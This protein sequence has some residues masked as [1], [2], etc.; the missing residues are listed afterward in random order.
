MAKSLSATKA[1][2]ITNDATRYLKANGE[3]LT[4]DISTVATAQNILSII[5]AFIAKVDGKRAELGAVQNRLESTIRNQSN[6]SENVAATRSRIRDTDFA[7][8][9]RP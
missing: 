1:A 5:D 3:E 9:L 8:R 2:A 6:V 4:F 7:S